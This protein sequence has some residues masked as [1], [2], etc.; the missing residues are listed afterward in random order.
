MKTEITIRQ[1]I[2][3]SQYV[4]SLLSLMKQSKF[5]LFNFKLIVMKDFEKNSGSFSR[6][7]WL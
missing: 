1:T 7:N 6:T 4:F 5:N 3:F 2:Y